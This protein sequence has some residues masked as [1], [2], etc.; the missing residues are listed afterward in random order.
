MKYETRYLFTLPPRRDERSRPAAP[1]PVEP[2]EPVEDHTGPFNPILGIDW[3]HF[4]RG[5]PEFEIG[6]ISEDILRAGSAIR[7]R[8]RSDSTRGALIPSEPLVG[9]LRRA[10]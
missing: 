10:I 1:Q 3:G 5:D 6:V 8:A 7:D 9:E 4:P 2:P